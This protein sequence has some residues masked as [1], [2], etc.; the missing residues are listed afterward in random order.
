MTGL[1]AAR[2]GLT[3]AGHPGVDQPL[4]HLGAV[5]RAQAQTLGDARSETLDQ[6]VGLGDEFEDKLAAL[7]GLEVGD[8]EAP[9][10]QHGVCAAGPGPVDAHDVGTEVAEDHRGVRA[11]PDSGEFDDSQSCQRSRHL[12]RPPCRQTNLV[13]SPARRSRAQRVATNPVRIFAAAVDGRFTPVSAGGL[14][15]SP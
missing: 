6:H 12:S 1:L 8:D 9:V 4:V 10:A 14:K 2:A 15:S 11:G 5:F 3:P 7:L 13:R